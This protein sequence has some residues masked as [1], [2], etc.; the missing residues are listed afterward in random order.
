MQYAV[1]TY[2]CGKAV[3]DLD[4]ELPGFE[5]PSQLLWYLRFL[6]VVVQVRSD[7]HAAGA[8]TGP[9]RRP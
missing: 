8:A 4:G 6:N 7:E 2:L 3:A 9:D 5:T 1:V